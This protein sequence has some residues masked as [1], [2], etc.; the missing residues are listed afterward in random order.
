MSIWGIGW[1][2]FS[3]NLYHV[4]RTLDERFPDLC[5]SSFNRSVKTAFYMSMGII[6]TFC[7]ETF[8]SNIYF[9]WI[10]FEH[11]AK[12]FSAL[13]PN[14]LEGV[15][16][17]HYKFPKNVYKSINFFKTFSK[18]CRSRIKHVRTNVSRIK[19]F[20]TEI[21]VFFITFIHWVE[22]FGLP[23]N[24]SNSVVKTAVWV[25]IWTF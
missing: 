11:L 17:L 10:N 24:F 15:S 9:H 19:S 18:G 2:M 20:L 12:T 8:F 22:N 6:R 23:E 25:S 16:K 7:V 4:F 3:S 5:Q 14:N 21:F 13:W 1:K